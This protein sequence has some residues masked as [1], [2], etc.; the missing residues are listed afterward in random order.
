M[1]QVAPWPEI[2]RAVVASGMTQPQIAAAC[3]CGQA[4]ISDLLRGNTTEP[5]HSLG[6]RLLRLGQS[7]GVDVDDYL[8]LALT[9]AKPA[10]QEIRNAA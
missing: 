9:A 6:Q 2:I 3:G 5:R 4:T 7:R 8:N 1:E 10:P